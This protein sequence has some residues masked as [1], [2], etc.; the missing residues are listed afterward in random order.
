MV[1]EN[2]AQTARAGATEIRGGGRRN[3][4]REPGSVATYDVATNH[5]DPSIKT[6]VEV[7]ERF[8]IRS[9]ERIEG[10]MFSFVEHGTKKTTILNQLHPMHDSL[11]DQ[12]HKEMT[13]DNPL[14]QPLISLLTAWAEVELSHNSTATRDL[15]E[16]IRFDISLIIKSGHVNKNVAIVQ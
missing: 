11:L 4:T 16:Q 9:G 5:L 8:E 3:S 6:K 1:F 13:E 7:D 10:A 2:R 12:V 15:M 14:G